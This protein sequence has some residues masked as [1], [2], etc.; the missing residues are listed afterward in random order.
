LSLLLTRASALASSACLF[1]PYTF[2]SQSSVRP[3]NSFGGFHSFPRRGGGCCCCWARRGSP[4]ARW[5]SARV[6][7][8]PL[9]Q[10]AQTYDPD[11]FSNHGQLLH[12]L[13]TTRTE[14]VVI[15]FVVRIGPAVNCGFCAVAHRRGGKCRCW[16]RR[17]S[18]GDRLPIRPHPVV[19]IVDEAKI[20]LGRIR[21]HEKAVPSFA[22][23]EGRG[24]PVCDVPTL[25]SRSRNVRVKVTV[26]GER[27][28]RAASTL[29]GCSWP[30]TARRGRSLVATVR[31]VRSF[32][33]LGAPVSCPTSQLPRRRVSRY[34]DDRISSW[35]APSRSKGRSQRGCAS[36]RCER[37]SDPVR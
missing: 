4:E 6:H 19:R 23:P 2:V 21:D 22:A 33:I 3:S 5:P 28:S 25:E 27:T 36:L 34:A 32:S 9:L 24:G 14:H 35:H 18:G 1:G 26:G 17:C 15:C 8:Y 10:L 16:W 13:P 30:V 20:S 7:E 12:W 29:S 11:E 37:G 31:V